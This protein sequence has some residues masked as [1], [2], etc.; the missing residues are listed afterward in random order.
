MESQNAQSDVF[1]VAVPARAA[2]PADSAAIENR[3]RAAACSARV[4]LHCGI[5]SNPTAPD[6]QYD[7]RGCHAD[8]QGRGNAP[9]CGVG[10]TAWAEMAD[11]ENAQAAR[12]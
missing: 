5:C 4:R 2:A 7:L 12:G 11:S 8:H 3:L 9:G 10:C 6:T 1:R